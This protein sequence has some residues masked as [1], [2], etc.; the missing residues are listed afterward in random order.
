MQQHDVEAELLAIVEAIRQMRPEVRR[1]LLLR[2]RSS[3]LLE[4][5]V[6]L[7]DR[8]RL[9]VAPALG[10]GWSGKVRP[11][12]VKA[13]Q[14]ASATRLPQN[15]VTARDNP[16]QISQP[17]QAG[18]QSPI[19]GKVVTGAPERTLATGDPHAMPPLPGQAPEQPITIIF[20]GGSRGNPGQGYGSY[21]LR[22]P[23]LPQQIVQLRFG[24]K[25]TNNEAEYDTLIA[26]L[27]GVIKKL[28]ESGA[29]PATA[30]V[31]VRGDSLLVINQVLN[32]WEC[33]E[34]RLQVRRERVR[35]LL[36][37]FGVWSLLHH[38]R[39]QSVEVLGH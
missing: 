34:P 17:Q 31:D 38:K 39:E 12:Q 32:K 15:F 24:E 26:A 37:R 5:E 19:R 8:N 1:R 36:Q 16:P 20:D 23:G 10:K 18:Y 30:N 33:K 13:K 4:P 2:L 29:S 7:A 3:G 9:R 11:L 28:E 25:V 6:L 14:S 22:W 27:E 21:A 35:Q